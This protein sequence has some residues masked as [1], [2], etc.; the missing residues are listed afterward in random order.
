[1]RDAADLRF[2]SKSTLRQH[3]KQFDGASSRARTI[4][5]IFIRHNRQF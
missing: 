5:A 1:M 4:H 2:Y 3:A